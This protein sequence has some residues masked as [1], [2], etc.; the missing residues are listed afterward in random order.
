MGLTSITGVFSRYFIVGFFLPAYIAVLAL[1]YFASSAFIPSELASHSQ[2]TQVL[3]L[4]AVALVIAMGL[5]GLSYYITRFYEGYPLAQAAAPLEA[6]RLSRWAIKWLGIRALCRGATALQRRRYDRLCAIRGDKNRPAGDRARAGL[7]VDVWFPEKREALLPTRVGNAIRAFERHSNVRW[8]LDG[9]T[10]W[11]RIEALLAADDRELVVNAKINLYVFL[12]ASLGAFVVGL[13]L[14]IDKAVN[15]PQPA[16]EW[17]LYVIPFL[18]SYVLY[19]GAISGA[20]EWGDAVRS[21]IDLHRLELYE[22][23]ASERRRRSTMS[24]KS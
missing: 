6:G 13:C 12:N 8:G 19:R 17:V 3:I 4:G 11:P 22:K 23:L 7:R 1:W 24:D 16:W 2:A 21:S 20:T 5:S 9:V 15:V 18:L 10:V 14:V